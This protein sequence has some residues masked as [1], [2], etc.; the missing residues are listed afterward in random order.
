MGRLLAVVAALALLGS[1]GVLSGDGRSSPPSP[2]APTMSLWE[3]YSRGHITIRQ[4][5]LTYQNG[6]QPVTAPLGFEV[7]NSGDVAVVIDEF[8]G[9]LS[10][11]PRE[12]RDPSDTTQDGILTHATASRGRGT[13]EAWSSGS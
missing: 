13:D 12:N 9:L 7:R 1:L 5:D 10:P 3:A 6:G 2:A 4:V 11:N 8:V